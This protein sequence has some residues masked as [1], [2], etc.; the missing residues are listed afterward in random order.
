[1]EIGGGISSLTVTWHHKGSCLMGT[2]SLLTS[3]HQ[4]VT[5]VCFLSHSDVNATLIYGFPS[6]QW[7]V[8][9]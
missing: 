3:P 6:I 8:L 2:D 5:I 4:Y 9:S 1:M 7:V